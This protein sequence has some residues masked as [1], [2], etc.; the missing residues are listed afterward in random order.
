MTDAVEEK[1]KKPE[2]QHIDSMYF[3]VRELD[4]IHKRIDRVELE[5]QGLRKDLDNKF[6]WMI[7]LIFVSWI[8]IMA[9]I[10]SRG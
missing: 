3:V 5:I 9:A 2:V 1:E 7:G 4:Q 6:R 8:T 10:F